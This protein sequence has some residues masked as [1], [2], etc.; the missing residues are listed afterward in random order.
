LATP[1][2]I[3]VLA[4]VHPRY[5]V[6]QSQFFEQLQVLAP[7]A[8]PIF[9][10]A[11]RDADDDTLALMQ[12][13]MAWGEY[14]KRRRDRALANQ[15]ALITEIQRL[16]AEGQARAQMLNQSPGSATTTAATVQPREDIATASSAASS[17]LPAIGAL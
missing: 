2:E 4:V 13:R 12:R 5:Q 8:A 3:A 14:T 16:S 11:Y 10:R 1:A 7:T 17:L 6:C 9:A 15:Q